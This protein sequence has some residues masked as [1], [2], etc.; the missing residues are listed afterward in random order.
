M[1]VDVQLAITALRVVSE[2]QRLPLPALKRLTDTMC[3]RIFGLLDT[4]SGIGA[5]VNEDNRQLFLQ[6]FKV[7]VTSL[8]GQCHDASKAL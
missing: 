1:C 6:C 3:M 7:S 2:I 8:R 4:Y 5:A